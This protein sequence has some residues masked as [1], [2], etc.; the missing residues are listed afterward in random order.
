MR[1]DQS[2]TQH[3]DAVPPG[4]QLLPDVPLPHPTYFPAGLAMG[5][6]FIFW[7]LITTWPVWLV[8]VVLFIA[9][10]A[11]WITEIRHEYKSR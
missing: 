6:A 1:D 3:S 10:L 8:G 9:A 5:V 11:G 7:G 2:T 4:W